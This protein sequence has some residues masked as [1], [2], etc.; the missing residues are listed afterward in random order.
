MR[1]SSVLMLPVAVLLYGTPAMTSPYRPL[2]DTAVSS[3][4]DSAA[5]AKVGEERSLPYSRGR[6]FADLDSYLTFRRQQAA[7]DLPWYEEVA[8]GLYELK[9]SMRPAA[10][11]KRFTRA[12]LARKFGFDR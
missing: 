12:E 6:S 9:T 7:I 5:R 10:A 11:P 8:P 1:P 3:A 2:P 4:Q